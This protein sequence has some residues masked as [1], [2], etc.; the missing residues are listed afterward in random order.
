MIANITDPDAIE[1]NLARA[2][3]FICEFTL[4]MMERERGCVIARSSSLVRHVRPGNAR[5]V[6]SRGA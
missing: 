2:A 3:N 5:Y 4:P 6:A 1:V